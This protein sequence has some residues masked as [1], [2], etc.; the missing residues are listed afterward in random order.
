MSVSGA[1]AFL[2]R[3]AL[4]QM[5]GEILANALLPHGERSTE[6]LIRAFSSREDVEEAMTAALPQMTGAVWAGLCEKRLQ[7]RARPRV[8]GSLARWLC[9]RPDGAHRFA[10]VRAEDEVPIIEVDL[11]ALDEDA[12]VPDDS[13]STTMELERAPVLAPDQV[14][15]AIELPDGRRHSTAVALHGMRNMAQLHANMRDAMR[16]LT[17]DD[18]LETGELRVQA[19][20]A[21]GTLVDCTSDTPLSGPVL[22]AVSLLVVCGQGAGDEAGGGE[23]SPDPSPSP[24]PVPVA[25]LPPPPPAPA[26][27]L[28]RPLPQDDADLP[29]AD[30][31]SFVSCMAARPEV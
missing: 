19:R 27:S 18:V 14:P 28:S 26:P 24:V 8:A 5:L 25:P 3:L 12:L 13:A 22:S 9:C 4:E 7:G 2:A 17:S 10:A 30:D 16:A 29:E 21:D 6:A 11:D 15:V 31:A 1:S 20:L 23:P